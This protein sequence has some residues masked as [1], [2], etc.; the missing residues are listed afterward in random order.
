MPRAELKAQASATPARRRA[1]RLEWGHLRFFLEL[2]RAGSL[3][4]AASRLGVD[5]NTVGRRVAALEAELGLPLFERGPQG[6]SRTPA[7]D[8]LAA[9]ASRV[10]EDVLALARHADAR[11]R[12]VAGTVRLTTASHLAAHLVVPAIPALLARHPGLVLEVAAD[13]RTFDL[14]RREA[15]L[16]LRM[17]RPREASPGLVA[18]KL[19]DVAYGLYAARGS[20]PARRGA[21]DLSSD[22]FVG[23]DDSLAGAPQ[24]RWL[25]RVAPGRRVVFRSNSTA[26][27][28]A[29]ARI[30]V[31]VAVLQ[32][33]VADQDAGLVRLEG[34][35]PASHELWL[36]VHADLRRS[37]RVE[38]V[39]EW[40]DEL[41]ARARPRLAGRA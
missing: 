32:R 16:A 11:D 40:V 22:G 24:E 34:P 6:W 9:L 38:A 41:V 36:L 33:F 20:P 37:P 23:L 28:L 29:A 4:R 5:R 35:E 26:S 7:G 10:E 3:S 25:Q 30:G 31:G 13:Q 27:L 19:S 21:V 39:I 2:V 1:G 8:E 14:T 17:G 15:D 12:A 18:R